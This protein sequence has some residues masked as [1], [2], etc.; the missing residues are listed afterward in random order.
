[1]PRPRALSAKAARIPSS[2]LRIVILKYETAQQTKSTPEVGRTFS[3]GNASFLFLF[4]FFV[5]ANR[6]HRIQL[7]NFLL[8]GVLLP[9][10]PL[11][12]F[13]SG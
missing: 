6:S 10:V 2:S 9:G 11:C 5:W 3:A 4:D 13:L 8:S 7:S 1:M 12:S